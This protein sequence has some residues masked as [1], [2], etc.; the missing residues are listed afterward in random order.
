MKLLNDLFDVILSNG[1][2]RLRI[3]TIDEFLILRRNSAWTGCPSLRVLIL[4]VI[5]PFD[6]EQIRSLCPNLR[7]IKRASESVIPS[8]PSML[9]VFPL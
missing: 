1:F 2:P 8:Q 3:C 9:S 7:Q 5:I 6:F 4:D